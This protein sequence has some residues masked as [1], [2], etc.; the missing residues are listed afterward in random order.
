[1]HWGR[2]PVLLDVFRPANY[3]IADCVT[4]LPIMGWRPRWD[5]S[6]GQLHNFIADLGLPSIFVHFLKSVQLAT[7]LHHLLDGLS[8][9]SMLADTW[10]RGYYVALWNAEDD[11]D[12]NTN[13]FPRKYREERFYGASISNYCDWIRD[14]SMVWLVTVDSV[15][16]LNIGVSIRIRHT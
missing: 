16:K 2:S 4:R 10:R 1:M 12:H 5:S 13:G 14:E 15:L 8:S 3:P 7:A 9:I 11:W 6:N